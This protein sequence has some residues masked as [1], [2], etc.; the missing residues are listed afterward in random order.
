M[1][2]APNPDFDPKSGV[3][4]GTV[5]RSSVSA[6]ARRTL[7]V[8]VALAILLPTSPFLLLAALG[9]RLSSP[10]PVLYRSQ[11]I[12][13]DGKRFAILKLRTMH[14]GGPRGSFL[15]V[16][17]DA[18]VF[19]LGWFLRKTRIDELPQLLNVLGGQMSLVGPRPRVPEVIERFYTP[20]MRRSLAHRP[21]LTS[22]GTLY[23]LTLE[24]A[25]GSETGLSDEDRYGAELLP[26]KV[27]ID[28]D[29]FDRA[30]LRSDLAV[31]A[32]TARFL[33]C[34]ASGRPLDL[35]PEFTGDLPKT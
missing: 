14:A 18:R 1:V 24:R 27:A 25:P 34:R 19:A 32:L 33:V 13:Q 7:D 11:R 2:S 4:P 35:P 29:Y 10:G 17:D 26:R 8:V 5:A 6:V 15:V 9:I 28:L 23:Q 3:L 22:P 30:T 31:I 21:G 12:G 20:E 16:Q